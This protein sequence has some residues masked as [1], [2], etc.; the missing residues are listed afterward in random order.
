MPVNHF[1]VESF[2][3]SLLSIRS[4]LDQY[5]LMVPQI[6]LG[7]WEEEW[8]H[9]CKAGLSDEFLLL[10]GGD[11]RHK[12]LPSQHPS[13]LSVSSVIYNGWKCCCVTK[14]IQQSYAS[15]CSCGSEYS[16][17]MNVHKLISFCVLL[18][19]GEGTSC[20][21]LGCTCVFYVALVHAHILQW[22]RELHHKAL[23]IK[24]GVDL[25]TAPSLANHLQPASER[26]TT[27][28][29]LMYL[30]LPVFNHLSHSFSFL[31]PPP[32]FP[33]LTSPLIFC[34]GVSSLHFFL[35]H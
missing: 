31:S 12:A 14:R 27:D 32:L 26:A 25:K 15:L 11:K 20:I 19:H 13:S 3:L 2:C 6:V 4:T 8:K 1:K 30:S 34:S 33:A 23:I 7:G 28:W 24:D 22:G 29:I 16:N 5:N 18:S 21:P 17:L 10:Q 9:G 35:H